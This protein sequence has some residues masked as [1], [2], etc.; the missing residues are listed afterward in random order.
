MEF[1][2]IK[3]RARKL[4]SNQTPSEKLFWSKVR[5]RQFNGLRFNRQYII[6]Y[7]KVDSP[8]LYFIVDFACFEKKLAIEID[9]KYHQ[10]MNEYDQ[11]RDAI[12]RSLGWKVIRFTNDQIFSI[13]NLVKEKIMSAI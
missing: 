1:W 4:R 3:Q 6:E 7:R 9:G 12:I 5:R 2:Q 10:F 13:W 8:N 11:E